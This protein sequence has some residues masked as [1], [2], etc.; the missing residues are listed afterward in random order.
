[1]AKS[2]NAPAG[3]PGRKNE[4]FGG[5]S[6]QSLSYRPRRNE[7]WRLKSRSL[8][9]STPEYLAKCGG[10]P[11]LEKDARQRRALCNE[12]AAIGFDI[13]YLARR[14]GVQPRRG[15]VR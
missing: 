10:D 11:A 1:M 3:E 8:A 13:E 15:D 4:H 14:Y 12:L 5:R 7:Y 6:P 9:Q 2:D